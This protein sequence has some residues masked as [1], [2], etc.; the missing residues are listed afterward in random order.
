MMQRKSRMVLQI[1]GNIYKIFILQCGQSCGSK[2]GMSFPSSAAKD[3]PH[4]LKS[5]HTC[6]LL[7][8]QLQI[9]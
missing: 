9:K 3:T 4:L 6:E 7:Y 8:L 5:L 2:T 1:I